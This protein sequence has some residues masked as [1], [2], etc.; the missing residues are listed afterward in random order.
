[1]LSERLL[2]QLRLTPDT[3]GGHMALS[4]AALS[5]GLV[6]SIPLGVAASRRPRLAGAALAAAGVVQTVPSIALLAIMVPL[7]AWALPEEGVRHSIGFWPAFLALTLYSLLPTLR[8]TVA[9]LAGVPASCVEAA[10]AMGMTARQQLLRVELPLAAP[11]I[12]AGIRTSTVWVVGIAT[13]ATPVGATCLGDHI[14]SGLRTLNYT[15]V[16]VGCALA[17]GLALAL[18]QMIRRLEQAVRQ[19]R[20]GRA[21]A[22]VAALAGLFTVA[23]ARPVAQAL[24]SRDGPPRVV[25]GAKTF[26][27]QYILAERLASAL[28]AAGYEVD[29]REN[30]GST[31][32][33]EALRNG[34]VDVCVDYTGT[35]WAT[36]LGESEPASRERT[37][38]EIARRLPEQYGI[39]CLGGL[40][41]ENA[42]ALAMSAERAARLGIRRIGDLGPRAASMSIGGDFEFFARPEWRRV[43]ERYGLRFGEQRGMDASLMYGAARSGAVDVITAF[44]TDGRILAFGLA[45]LE[46]DRE[47][48]PPY[49][50]VILLSRRAARDQRL[51]AALRPLLGRVGPEAM[52]EANHAVDV[53]GATSAEA[54]RRL[55][56]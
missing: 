12:V 28:R 50:A 18:D 46:D 4:L 51:Q 22:I 29:K 2:E 8:N 23:L 24:G 5:A 32:L 13:L 26:T 43:Q 17:A 38:A 42:Y 34:S 40:G 10:Q 52:R 41:F 1:M 44:S 16:M 19:R 49:D 11:V 7:L 6:V 14:F 36:I 3:L 47:A 25:V 54:A 48:F 37:M 31:I 55:A 15:A 56:P 30:L 27:E 21:A 45:V 20:A 9:G 53:L 35:I 33:F 39:V